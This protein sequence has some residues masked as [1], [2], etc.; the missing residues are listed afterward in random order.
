LSV[1]SDAARSKGYFICDG[2]PL[3]WGQYQ[4]SIVAASGKR[5]F[6]LRLPGACVDV[7]AAFGELLTAF[8]KKPRLFNRQ[9]AIMGKQ[10]AWTCRHERAKTDFGYSPKV[11]L[12]EGVKQTFDWYKT[13]GWL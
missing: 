3:T 10:I 8:D 4:A 12:E 1:Q 11:S 6:E 7:A 13:S 9:K 5:A 2:K